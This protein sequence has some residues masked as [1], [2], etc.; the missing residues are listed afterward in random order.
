MWCTINFL[1]ANQVHRCEDG[2]HLHDAMG[3][4]GHTLH[5]TYS[6]EA[7]RG[8]YLLPEP[9]VHAWRQS[10]RPMSVTR[11]TMRLRGLG[12]V[13]ALVHDLEGR[14]WCGRAEIVHHL[15]RRN[16]PVW[17]SLAPLRPNWTSQLWVAPVRGHCPLIHINWHH[18]ACHK[19]FKQPRIF[20]LC[21]ADSHNS[22]SPTLV[23]NYL[24]NV[25]KLSFKHMRNQNIVEYKHKTHKLI[26]E[27]L[28]TF[29]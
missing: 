3:I 24:V 2:E 18:A 28:P 29:A 7:L 13:V 21:D 20:A 23:Y 19:D 6:R 1:K 8:L 12:D 26:R 15:N 11:T 22:P 9:S 27:I 17:A 10:T 14:W 25:Y 5:F 16:A 4:W